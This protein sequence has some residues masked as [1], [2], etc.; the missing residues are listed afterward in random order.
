MTKYVSHFYFCTKCINEQKKR[1]NSHIPIRVFLVIITWMFSMKFSKR[2]RNLKIVF[3]YIGQLS[4]L[5][6]VSL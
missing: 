6:Y 4:C 5:C 2:V 3:V 1:S